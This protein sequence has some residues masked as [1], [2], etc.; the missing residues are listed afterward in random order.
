MNCFS[1]KC[2]LPVELLVQK[3]AENQIQIFIKKNVFIVYYLM[4][5]D[6]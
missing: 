2:N 6:T 4:D 5:F 1:L 3:V